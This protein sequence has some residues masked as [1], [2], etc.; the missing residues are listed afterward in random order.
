MQNGQ[1]EREKGVGGENIRSIA[2]RGHFN[3]LNGE[4]ENNLRTNTTDQ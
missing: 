1:K 3:F 4:R 2:G